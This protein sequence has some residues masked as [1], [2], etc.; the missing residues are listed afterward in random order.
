MV[1]GALSIFDSAISTQ[2]LLHSHH[3]RAHRCWDCLALVIEETYINSDYIL[4][5]E[6]S[7]IPPDFIVGGKEKLI[8]L[9]AQG[10]KLDV[11]NT[12]RLYP[13]GVGSLFYV[14]Y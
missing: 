13:S 3:S 7:H 8:Y 2:G 5:V 14:Y 11:S 4:L 10:G 9:C 1:Q 12:R 6:I